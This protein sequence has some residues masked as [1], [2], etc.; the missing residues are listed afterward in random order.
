M[1][2]VPAT[3]PAGDDHGLKEAQGIIRADGS[4]EIESVLVEMNGLSHPWTQLVGAAVT[5]THR[6]D[7]ELDRLMAINARRCH[8]RRAACHR[9][10]CDAPADH[11]YF[12]GT[13]FS[14]RPALLSVSR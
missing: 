5:T 12:F 8:T 1:V 13:S 10:T 2:V 3:W 4:P 9:S 7:S 14:K 6:V 11:G